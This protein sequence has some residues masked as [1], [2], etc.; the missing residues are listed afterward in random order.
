MN[1]ISQPVNYPNAGVS[2]VLTLAGTLIIVSKSGDVAV[3][4]TRAFSK[5]AT[6]AEKAIRD[7]ATDALNN[8]TPKALAKLSSPA[9]WAKHLRLSSEDLERLANS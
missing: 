8:P 9:H 6:S 4:S 2:A 5:N 7:F 3:I 1:L